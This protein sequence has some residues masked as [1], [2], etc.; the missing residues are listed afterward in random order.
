MGISAEF[1]RFGATLVNVQ[2]A[3]SALT[4]TELVASFWQHKL[5]VEGSRL[6]Y[7]DYLSRWRG[8][9]SRLLGEHLMIAMSEERPVRMVMART[10]NPRSIEAGSSGTKARNVFKARPEWIGRITAFGGDHFTVEFD[11]HGPDTGITEQRF[12][13]RRR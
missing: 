8:N 4:K 7:R 11:K 3:V 6:V 12:P 10:D 2:W 5:K 1:A 13:V 9:G